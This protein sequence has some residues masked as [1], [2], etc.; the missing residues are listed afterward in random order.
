MESGYATS[1]DVFLGLAGR[2]LSPG[3]D[4]ATKDIGYPAVFRSDGQVFC[5]Y[6]GN[7]MGGGN[8]IG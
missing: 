2:G 5:L 4:R 7:D 1:S 3:P 6:N 8:R